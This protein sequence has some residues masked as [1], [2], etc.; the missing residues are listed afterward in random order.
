MQNLV[1]RYTWGSMSARDH[2]VHRGAGYQF[3]RIVPV[4]VMQVS[5]VLGID[6]YS[7]DSVEQA[8]T[9]FW[10]CADLLVRERVD[11]IVLGGAPV[12]AQLGRS[13]VL[14]L[15]RDLEQRTGI[16]GDAPIEAVIAAMHH[17]GLRKIAVGSRWAPELNARVAAYLE[18]GD[19]EVMGVTAR[20]QWAAQAAAMSFEDGLQ[21]ALDVGREAALL[22]PG[23]EA[24]WVAGGAAMALHVVP[25]LEAEFGKPVFT[26][27]TAEVWHGLVSPRVIDA[28]QGWGKLLASP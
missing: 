27:L 1:P 23:V 6:E 20:G 10:E 5:V 2:R 28:V 15:L 19:L 12:S 24:I 8:I 14:G 25:A 21:A 18:E 22:D 3:Y 9:S 7:A 17:F 16:P 11:R 4:D 13:R 26:N